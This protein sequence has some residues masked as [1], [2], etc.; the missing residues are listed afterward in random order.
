MQ[1]PQAILTSPAIPAAVLLAV[2][3][4][5]IAVLF[6]NSKCNTDHPKPAIRVTECT[7]DDQ[8]PSVATDDCDD[9]VIQDRRCHVGKCVECV[10]D[11]DCRGTGLICDG[12]G[13][14]VP[15]TKP[16]YPGGT[17]AIQCSC[18]NPTLT[19]KLSF[20]A[21]EGAVVS[22]IPDTDTMYFATGPP[23]IPSEQSLYPF[24]PDTLAVQPDIFPTGFPWYDQVVGLAWNSAEQAFYV[25]E[26]ALFRLWKISADGTNLVFLGTTIGTVD[27]IRGISFDP[28]TGHLLGS[29]P[30]RP[31]IYLIHKVNAL[32]I[33]IWDNIQDIGGA[34]FG[35]SGT[36]IHPYTGEIWCSWRAGGTP[37]N[38][39]YWI[40]TFNPNT[41][42]LTRACITP[43][44]IISS[45]VF[46]GKGRLWL[47]TGGKDAV[48]WSVFAYDIPPCATTTV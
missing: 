4:I 28:T 9:C 38:A 23:G 36:A 8:C 39:P 16:G 24:N 47:S 11:S 18:V 33:S 5:V 19:F 13:T 15:G 37:G 48:K 27:D 42:F 7:S 3:V 20:D 43:S 44:R 45:I 31:R 17:D 2:I 25:F 29:V 12:N 35:I 14:C 30:Y 41:R 26:R 46:D 40:G 21:T 34:V 22:Y 10:F 6:R 32:I 1:R